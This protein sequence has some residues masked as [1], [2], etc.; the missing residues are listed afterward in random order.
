MENKATKKMARKNVFVIAVAA[1]VVLA[2]VLLITQVLIPRN[3]YLLAEDLVTAGQ[4]GKAVEAFRALGNYSDSAQRADAMLEENPALCFALTQPGDIVT[5]GAYEQDG[6]TSNG[7]EPIEW[8]VLVQEEH[9]VLA[10]SRHVLDAKQYHLYE[11]TVL[12]QLSAL[13][14]WLDLDFADLVFKG[15]LRKTVESTGLMKQDYLEALEAMEISSQVTAYA[16]ANGATGD[17]WWL[18][19]NLS[20]EGNMIAMTAGANESANI[21]EVLGVRPA[22]WVLTNNDLLA[23]NEQA[24]AEELEVRENAYQQGLKLKSMGEFESAAQLFVTLGDYEDAQAQYLECCKTVEQQGRPLHEVIAVME[25]SISEAYG[26]FEEVNDTSM[27]AKEMEYICS[28]FFPYCGEFVFEVD[29]T[30]YSVQSDFL[31]DG[32]E[33]GAYWICL[34]DE[35]GLFTTEQDGEPVSFFASNPAVYGM[36]ATAQ[37]GAEEVKISFE[38][39]QMIATWGEYQTIETDEDGNVTAREDYRQL[40]SVTGVKK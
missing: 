30:A 6:D 7:A 39:D 22:I 31:Y 2:L 10:V 28:S 18:Y 35:G 15:D 34:K 33:Q 40:R 16:A 5:Y 19:E 29:G 3:A 23:D 11:T 24:V 21:T 20:Y 8:I 9:R 36:V 17:G 26:L 25:T 32:D 38:G 12:P 13:N 4:H 27:R 37:I 1:V 14:K